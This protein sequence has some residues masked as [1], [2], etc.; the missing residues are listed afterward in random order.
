MPL[1]QNPKSINERLDP[2]NRYVFYLWIQ[3]FAGSRL[4]RRDKPSPNST[5]ILR[6]QNVKHTNALSLCYALERRILHR[7]ASIT[8]PGNWA[9]VRPSCKLLL[10]CL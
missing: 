5:A 9:V 4:H 10:H 1:L 3:C 6:C 7:T 8:Q 2:T